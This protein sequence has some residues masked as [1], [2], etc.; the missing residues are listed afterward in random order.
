LTIPLQ[1][2]LAVL[3]NRYI[4][5]EVIFG[6]RPE[7][8]SDEVKDQ[9][10]VPIK[11]TVEIAEPMGS[12]SLV[13]LKAGSGNLIARIHREHLY[14][15]GEPVTVKLNLDKAHLFDSTTEVVIR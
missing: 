5:K 7:H 13:Y 10:H 6:I 14:H 12:E 3:A 1:G 9:S 11:S 8:L 4:G 2:R 15:L